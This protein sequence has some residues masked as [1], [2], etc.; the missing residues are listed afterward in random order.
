VRLPAELLACI[1]GPGVLYFRSF[2]RIPD[3][4]VR[5]GASLIGVVGSWTGVSTA[6]LALGFGLSNGS[7]VAI[8]VVV[9]VLATGAFLPFRDHHK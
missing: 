6:V 1:L 2:H 5:T 9:Y 4:P 3:L 7:A 8:L